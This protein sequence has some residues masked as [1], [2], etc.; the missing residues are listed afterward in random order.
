MVAPG[1]AFDP[2]DAAVEGAD[3]RHSAGFGVRY[4]VGLGEVEAVALV[5]LQRPKQQLRIDRLD[6]RQGD[7]SRSSS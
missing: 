1:H 7:R 5:D 2:V 6:S 3:F 4:E